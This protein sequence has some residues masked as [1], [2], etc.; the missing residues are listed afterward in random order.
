MSELTA[1]TESEINIIRGK[2]L[3]NAVT[4]EDVFLLL[5]HIDVLENLLD[6]DDM[7]DVHGTEGWRHLLRIDD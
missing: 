1:H 2:N 7:E 3:G 5:E 4:Q 6:E